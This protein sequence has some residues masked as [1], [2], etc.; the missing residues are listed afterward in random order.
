MQARLEPLLAD[1]SENVRVVAVE[2]AEA[3][4]RLAQAPRE[5]PARRRSGGILHVAS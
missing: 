1:S 3:L 5:G 4:R 2:T